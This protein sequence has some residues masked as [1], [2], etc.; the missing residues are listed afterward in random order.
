MESTNKSKFNLFI[1]KKDFFYLV[2][3]CR[4]Y[5]GFFR[6]YGRSTLLDYLKL[7]S[8]DTHMYYLYYL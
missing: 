2:R 7:N 1:S 6:F 4:K 3:T 8:V 5:S